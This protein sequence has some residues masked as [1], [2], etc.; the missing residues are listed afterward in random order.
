[1]EL[2]PRLR[3]AA[4]DTLTLVGRQLTRVRRHPG[5]LAG[6]FIFPAIL[7][8]L[9]GYIFGSAVTVPGGGDYR[10]Y[11]LPGLFGMSALTSMMTTM[12]M[13]ATD[14]GR[15]VMD[16]FRSMPTARSAVPIAQALYDVQLGLVS[17]AIMSL[18]GLVVGWSPHRGVLPTVGAYALIMLLRSALSW[19]GV[20]LGLVVKN[21][22]AADQLGP[23]VLPISMT[24][25]SFVP[26]DHMPGWLQVVCDWN[27]V[28]ALVAALRDLFGD[29]G[30]PGAHAAWPEAHPVLTTFLWTGLIYAVF[31]PLAVREIGRAHV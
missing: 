26:T 25:N 22:E 4:T 29:P 19:A 8:L 31:V 13:T 2:T 18:I 17:M 21:E 23:L 12:L 24:S 11:L 14:A 20:W 30:A 15:G 5:E 27:P 7:V 9:F 16:R 1:M 6:A 3:W 10:E 28:S